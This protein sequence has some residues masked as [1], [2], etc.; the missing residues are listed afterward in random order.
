MAVLNVHT[1]HYM[2]H[3]IPIPIFC[4]NSYQA[5]LYVAWVVVRARACACWFMRDERWSLTDSNSYITALGSR[6]DGAS[7]LVVSLLTACRSLI[8]NTA[9]PRH[10]Y[11][12]L[13]STF[14]HCVMDVVDCLARDVGMSQTPR[15]GWIPELQELPVL[16][17]H[18]DQQIQVF[19]AF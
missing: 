17:T 5:E 19:Q 4:D 14:L 8:Q 2:L 12:H 7:P 1:G 13:T 6:N 18:N 11:S 16:L 9:F 10:L 3:H 15:Y